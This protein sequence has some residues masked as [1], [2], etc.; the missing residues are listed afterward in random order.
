MGYLWKPG[1]ICLEFESEIY[2]YFPRAFSQLC[3]KK[4]LIL[5]VHICIGGGG[6]GGGEGAS[7]TQGSKRRPPTTEVTGSSPVLSIW[8]HVERVRQHSV[9][10]R[11][12]SPGS[13]VS[14]H[15]ESW[16]GGLEWDNSWESNDDRICKY[17]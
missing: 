8:S 11:G 15:R 9:E 3:K 4:Q 5:F 7:V 17:R 14:S 2:F 12:F 13:S 1:K 10:S 16:Q 6:G